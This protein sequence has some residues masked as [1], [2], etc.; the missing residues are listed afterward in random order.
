M[1]SKMKKAK[2][3][4]KKFKVIG[5]TKEP[6]KRPTTAFPAQ[7]KGGN[8]S[9]SAVRRANLCVMRVTLPLLA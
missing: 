2:T 3:Q 6:T 9:K 5:G 4:R 1:G 7:S 8:V